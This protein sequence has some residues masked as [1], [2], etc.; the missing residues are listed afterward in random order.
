M[1]IGGYS[2]WTPAEQREWDRDLEAYEK[3][4]DVE[5]TTPREWSWF[6]PLYKAYIVESDK[7]RTYNIVFSDTYPA[8]TDVKRD[9][10]LE[11]SYAVFAEFDQILRR[12]LKE[13]SQIKLQ[14]NSRK[15]PHVVY[16]CYCTPATWSSIVMEEIIAG[17]NEQLISPAVLRLG[18]DLQVSFV[19]N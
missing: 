11:V 19:K 17:L 13:V 1:W 2:D 7:S 15:Y 10:P 8:R 5:P 6:N 14:V 12:Q 9:I 3:E 4:I 18:L 16:T